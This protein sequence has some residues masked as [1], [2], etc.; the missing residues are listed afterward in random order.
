M[1]KNLPLVSVVITTKNEEKNIENCLISIK[2]QTYQNIETIVVDNDS[3]DKTK[4]LSLKYTE[5]VYDKGPE[6][7]AQRNYGMINKSHGEYVIYIDADMI[8]SPI[9]IESC[10][11][12]IQQTESVALHIP[13]IVLG[14]NYFSRVRRFE[15]SF[16]DGTPIDGARFFHRSIFLNV[17]GFDEP[18]FIKGSGEDWDIDKLVKQYGTIS[19]LPHYF[20]S[21]IKKT[22]KMQDFIETRGVNH[23]QKFT[24][25]YHNESEFE[26]WPYLKKKAYYSLG[27]DGYINK[28][29]V[30]DPDIQKQF[31]LVYRFWTVFTENGKWKRLFSHLD[32]T[33]GVYFL[34]MC[35]GFVYLF[36]KML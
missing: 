16:Y 13:E 5:K 34:R 8:L 31:G 27:F 1:N 7:S 36:R 3:S 29:G 26:L 18:L 24:G 23:A 15:R 35:V 2:E 25:I 9:L 10:V 19:L 14:K 21:L 11:R 28:W 32:L 22:W 20:N 6:R 12:N 33:I 30:D 17:G 4:E